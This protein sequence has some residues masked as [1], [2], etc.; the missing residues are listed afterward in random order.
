MAQMPESEKKILEEV[1]YLRDKY[2]T[3]DKPVPFC[4]LYLYHPQ[5]FRHKCIHILVNVHFRDDTCDEHSG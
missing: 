4:G 1:E 2:F 5:A 3:Y